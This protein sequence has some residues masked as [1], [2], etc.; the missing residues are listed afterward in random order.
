MP[1]LDGTI[2]TE[3]RY[4]LTALIGE[5]LYFQMA[6]AVGVLHQK[7]R[8]ARNFRLHLDDGER[9][10]LVLRHRRDYLSEEILEIIATRRLPD[11]FAATSF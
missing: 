4:R 1:S 6:T 10:R 9:V 7:D 5:D 11:A 2:A 8:R 3:Q